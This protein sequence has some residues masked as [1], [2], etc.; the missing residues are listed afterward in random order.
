[1][2]SPE[3]VPKPSGAKMVPK[4][5]G[6]RLVPAL[7]GAKVV[8]SVSGAKL[9]PKLS[10]AKLVPA[11]SGAKLVPK[12]SGARLVPKLGGA[13]LVPKLN[14]AELDSED[15]AAR[16]LQWSEGDWIKSDGGAS[17]VQPRPARGSCLDLR[18]PF[19]K[20]KIKARGKSDEGLTCEFRLVLPLQQCGRTPP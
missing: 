15:V 11:L 4:L 3:L 2:R 5:N 1:M 18:P 13:K 7:S 10:G 17:D 12:L 6:A 8:P 20:L 9:V 19:L 16:G 14:G